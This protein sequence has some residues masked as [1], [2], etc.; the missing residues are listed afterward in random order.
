MAI[1]VPAPMHRAEVLSDDA[2]LTSVCRVHGPKSR[3]WPRK[4][5]IGTEVDHV[6]CVLD[7]YTFKVKRTSFRSNCRGWEH[8]VAGL[9]RPPHRLLIDISPSVRPTH[10][11]AVP[12]RL[13]K[14]GAMFDKTWG[15]YWNLGHFLLFSDAILWLI[16]QNTT[17]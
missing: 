10:S 2:C 15:P 12:A 4:T 14:V 13:M 11:N 17:F 7:T 3:T 1:Y 8:I 5:K 16:L 6:T 9:W